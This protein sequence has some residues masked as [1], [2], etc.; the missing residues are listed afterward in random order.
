MSTATF[1]ELTHT[2]KTDGVV[3]PSVTQVLTLAGISD[4]SG[5]PLH[6]LERAAAIGTAVH[7]ATE[8]LEQDDLDME[9]LDPST[10]GYVKAYQL[11]KE[12]TGFKAEMVEYRTVAECS[13]FKYG[14]C[15][16]RV[17][18]IEGKEYVLD[19]KTS[20]RPQPSWAIQTAV[21]GVCGPWGLPIWPEQGQ[22]ECEG[23]R[24]GDSH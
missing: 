1:T 24:A 11:F 3:V 2:Y 16:D 19:I 21:K 4:V 12:V 9:S 22:S 14:M 23:F 8:L 6:I 5:V 15:V 7:Q 13:G 10:V 18:T 20:S 17:G